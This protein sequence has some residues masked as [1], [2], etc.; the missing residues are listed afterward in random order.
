MW[1][2]LRGPYAEA[3]HLHN[4][5]LE[6]LYNN[7]LIGLVLLL[8]MHLAVLGDLLFARKVVAAP[9]NP[10]SGASAMNLLIIGTFALYL[11]L[12]INGLFTPAFGG[13]P[14]AHF[15]IFLGALGCSVA[16]RSLADRVQNRILVSRPSHN[17]ISPSFPLA[18]PARS[19]AI[20]T[21]GL[22]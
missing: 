8:G 13:R 17:S 2:N 18:R 20:R 7:G 10:Q 4:G 11:N 3:G 14:T 6:A 22:S 16:L 21:P 12:L 15:M 5:F 19:G 1:V 9:A